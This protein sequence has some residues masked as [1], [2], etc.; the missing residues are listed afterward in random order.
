MRLSV[1][2]AYGTVGNAQAVRPFAGPRQCP[3]SHSG[4]GSPEP[5]LAPS[6]P[7]LGLLKPFASFG[8][9][10]VPYGPLMRTH[11]VAREWLRALVQVAE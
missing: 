6:D 8:V 9:E 11:G 4:I 2:D 7:T 1:A 10:R 3:K 5:S